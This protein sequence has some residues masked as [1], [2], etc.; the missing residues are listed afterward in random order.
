MKILNQNADIPVLSSCCQAAAQYDEQEHGHDHSHGAPAGSFLSLESKFIICLVFSLPLLLHMILPFH[1]LHNDKVQLILTT[2]VFI[3]GLLHFGHSAYRSLRAGTPNMDVLIVL[4]SGAAFIYSLVG[5]VFNLGPDYLFYE[6][7]ASIFTIVLFGNMLEKLSVKKT[8]SAISELSKLQKVPAKRLVTVSG[9]EKIEEIES[10]DIAVGDILAVNSGDKIPTDSVVIWG[11]ALVNE[12]MIT[13]ESLPV[14]HDVSSKVVGGTIVTDGSIKIRATEIGSETVLSKI[15]G[16]VKD[17]QAKKPDIQRLADRISLVFVPMVLLISLTTFLIATTFFG[18]SFASALLQAIAVLVIAC[19]CALGLAT[20]AAVMV[21]VGKAVKSGL[22]IKE[23]KTLERL[24]NVKTIIF[25]KTGTL[26]NG[27]FKITKLE[28][29]GIPEDSLKSLVYSL[30]RNSSH[31]LA[32]SIVNELEGSGLVE[33]KEVQEEK[34]VGIHAVTN[35]G[36]RIS[37]GA[38]K[39]AE[40]LSADSSHSVY[41]I[42]DGSL[43]GV[44]DLEDQVKPESADLIKNLGSLG[45]ECIIL[46]GDSEEK[47]K[48]V[49]DK[50]GIK[51]YYSGKSP[52]EKLDLVDQIQSKGLTAFVGDGINDAPALSKAAVGI[53]LSSASQVAIQSAQVLLVGGQIKQLSS[54]VEIARKTLVTIKQNLFWA[55]SYNIIA[56]PIAAF[57]FLTPTIA[58]FAMSFSDVIIILNSLRLKTFKPSK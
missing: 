7:A 43:A 39:I 44:I 28:A 38:Y 57:G 46:S 32:K 54:A 3:I 53:S 11:S 9:Q 29:Y 15:I 41:I 13:G 30:E 40:K 19:P 8:S 2:P 10:K 4:G 6:T 48:K 45:I 1:F 42:K 22:L 20:P 14:R 56:I 27:I 51:R 25:D 5:T 50:V 21:G 35:E 16:M 17:A 55:F 26:T 47:C 34:G 58:A 37:V 33:L 18:F 12:S 49:A 24:A 23:G 31:P 52:K 36:S